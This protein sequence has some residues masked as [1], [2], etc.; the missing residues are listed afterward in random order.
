MNT[1]T[2]SLQIQSASN[3]SSHCTDNTQ[4]EVKSTI[5]YTRALILVA[6]SCAI[7]LFRLR[8]PCLT[9]FELRKF[10]KRLDDTVQ[11]CIEEGQRASFKGHVSRLQKR[12]V[13]IENEWSSRG[14]YQWSSVYGYLWALFIAIWNITKCYDQAQVVHLYVLNVIAHKRQL[15]DGIEY[16]HLRILGQ[17]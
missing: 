7:L 6:L 15:H 2:A 5:T 1:L 12:I 8:Y 10:V 3:L 14:I 17:S 16:Q 9:L 11:K 4:S 13:V